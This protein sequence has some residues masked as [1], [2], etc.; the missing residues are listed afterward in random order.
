[1]VQS[2]ALLRKVQY[3]S[4][5]FNTRIFFHTG[6]FI[7]QITLFLFG[8][9]C[10]IV[11]RFYFW[12]RYH[13]Y[14]CRV[15]YEEGFPVMCPPSRRPSSID[16]STAFCYGLSFLSLILMMVIPV[17]WSNFHWKCSLGAEIMHLSDQVLGRNKIGNDQTRQTLQQTLLSLEH[18]NSYCRRK[19][20]KVSKPEETHKF[21]VHLGSCLWSELFIMWHYKRWGSFAVIL[22]CV[23]IS[24][25]LPCFMSMPLHGWNATFL[26]MG[27]LLFFISP[28][29]SGILV[30]I[31]IP[32]ITTSHSPY[33]VPL[34]LLTCWC[35][36]NFALVVF[37]FVRE[38]HDEL[39]LVR[40]SYQSDL[41][42]YVND[43]KVRDV[44][45]MLYIRGYGEFD[46]K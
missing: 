5:S 46:P 29:F 44:D 32:C 36:L 12:E 21:L 35:I 11:G 18:A 41:P 40:Y 26:I 22:L 28:M 9:L 15:N 25:A 27:M 42:L 3:L 20:C 38:S 34:T 39:S 37:S 30:L 4:S 19:Q 33:I 16:F 43:V 13:L 31:L 24:V 10:T 7:L 6:L 45:V 17:L 23:L 1:M 2:L 8:V 14:G